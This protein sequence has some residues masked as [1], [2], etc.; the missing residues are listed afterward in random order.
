[1]MEVMDTS[2]IELKCGT[3]GIVPSYQPPIYN[4]RF[5]EEFARLSYEEK[6]LLDIRK[7]QSSYGAMPYNMHKNRYRGFLPLEDTRVILRP[8][9]GVAG[10]DYIN[11]NYISGEVNGSYRSYIACQAP[12]TSTTYDFWR[13]VWEQRTGVIVMIVQLEEGKAERYWPLDGETQSHGRF[14]IHCKQSFCVKGITVRSILIRDEQNPDA[15]TREI[16]HLHFEH[17]PDFGVTSSE[18]LKDLLILFSKFRHRAS[19][20]YGLTG[21]SIVH[22]S[23]GLGRTGVFITCHILL[24]KIRHRLLP[25]VYDSLRLVRIQRQGMVRT[26]EQYTSIFLLLQ[27]IVQTHQLRKSTEEIEPLE[28]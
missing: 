17:W 6:E 24:D 4:N 5:Q 26:L 14:L 16:V 22:C 25:N 15:P 12:L 3:F 20:Q 8:V 1:M 23:A 7:E 13:M 11:A 19:K 9:D 27:D 28:S 18:S 21:P 2:G 10:S